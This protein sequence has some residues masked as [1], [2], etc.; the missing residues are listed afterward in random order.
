[1]NANER[2]AWSGSALLPD[3]GL[4]AFSAASERE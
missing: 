4:L 3:L 2:L 1:M